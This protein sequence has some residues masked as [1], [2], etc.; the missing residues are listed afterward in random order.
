MFSL[1]GKTALITGG[2][3]VL[4]AGMSK[5]LAAAGAQVAVL[6]RTL[7]KAEAVVAEIRA[8][9]GTAIAIAADVLNQ[10][11]VHEAADQVIDRFGKIDILVNAAGGNAPQATTSPER[12]FFDLPTAVLKEVF[13]LNWLGTL[14]PT[15][16]IGAHMAGRRSGT[17]INISSMAAFRPMTRVLAYA[18]AKAAI[19]NFTAWLATYLATEFSPNIRVNALAPG[20][21]FT[22]QNRFLLTDAETGK[23]TERGQKIIDHTPMRR[24]GTPDDLVGALIWLSSDA[25]Q[26]VTGAVIP[27]D[28]G[29]SA[30]SGV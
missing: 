29:F 12:H 7:A 18:S 26:F 6:G 14:I 1:Q 10:A 19:N 9:G 4:G 2:S 24:F 28:G 23:L 30:Y 27:I 22:E 13:D 8:Q 21:F 25:A 11:Q 20:F 3:G 16:A 5:G 15:Q 17:I